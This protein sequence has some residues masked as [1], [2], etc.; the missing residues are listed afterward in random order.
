MNT[1]FSKQPNVARLNLYLS[2]P[3]A[4]GYL[5]DR[6][7]STLFADPAM[8]MNDTLYAFLMER[9]FRR[10]GNHV[11]RH[12]CDDCQACMAVRVP[13]AEFSLSRSLRRVWHRNQDLTI[14]VLPATPT[15]ERFNLYQRYVN[16]RHP[17]G[18]MS[19]PTFEDFAEFLLSSWSMTRFVEFRQENRLLMVAVVDILP[20]AFS[21]VYTFFD[22]DESS[23]SLG[24]HAVL[25]QIEES[26]GLNKP[27][28]YLGYWI[29]NCQKMYYKSRFQ[30]LELYQSQRWVRVGRDGNTL[31]EISS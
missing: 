23:R 16:G 24:T 9:S 28:L 14:R 12:H 2:K 22:P 4:C 3:H 1:V 20:M 11:Y 10:S 13:V 29:D 25:W 5:L 30:P 31:K 17:D 19:H 21:A 15:Q 6:Q 7:A 18:P 27:H 8:P 26:K